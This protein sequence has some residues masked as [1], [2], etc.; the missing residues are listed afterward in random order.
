MTKN[1][2]ICEDNLTSAYCI[3]AMLEKFG[4]H[5]Q[6]AQNAKDTLELLKKNKYDLLT[7]DLLLPDKNGL[8]LV[9]ELQSI[10]FVKD[11]P[12]IVISALKKED[13]DLNFS[14]NI[15]A[16][17]EKSFDMKTLEIEVEKI[18]KQKNEKKAE[19][20]HV[21]NDEDLLS[22]I[23]LTLS[24]IAN[25]TQVNNLSEAKDILSNKSFDIIILDYVFPEGTSD[26]LIPTIKSGVNKNAKLVIFS[27]YE[28]SKIIERYVDKIFIKTSVSFDEFKECIE[29]II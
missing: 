8:E 9:K 13:S 18:M 24:D 19:I 26:K 29:N 22:L 21:E 17:I 15:I 1:A 7:L 28:E 4:Y 23:E 12:I 2:L 6:I 20:L 10:E 14:C 5:T 27:A 16:W 25:V 3:K 11:L